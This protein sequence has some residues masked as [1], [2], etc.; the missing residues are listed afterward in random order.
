MGVEAPILK[1]SLGLQGFVS[2]FKELSIKNQCFQ[3]QN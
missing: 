3:H 2:N 1:T